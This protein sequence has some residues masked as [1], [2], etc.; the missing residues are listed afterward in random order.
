MNRSLV[1]RTVLSLLFF[2]AA[3]V[4]ASA[5][6]LVDVV[7][8][9][10]PVVYY[11]ADVPDTLAQ[12]E[13][14]PMAELWADPQVMAFFAPL[15]E[16]LEGGKW[17]E[18][19]RKETG[20]GLD[21]IMAMFTG[22]MVA[23]LESFEFD[24]DTPDD[25]PDISMAV[26]ADVGD[27][28]SKLE[29]LILRQEERADDENEADGDEVERTREVRDFRGIDLHIESVV[30]DNEVTDEYG[31]AVVEGV[32]AF[33]F[34]IATLE[35]AIAG[36]LDG[37]VED[38]LRSGVNFA[39]ITNH[40]RSSDAWF[41]FDIEPWVPTA[42]SAL[43]MG[44]ASAQ[45]AGSPFPVDP[46][47][48]MD[49]LGIESMQALFGAV[50]FDDRTTVMD[51]GLTYTEDRGLIK[52]AAYGPQVAPR[53]IFI[54]IDSDGFSSAT[55]DFADSWSALVD[56]INGVN[57]SLMGM[58]TMQLESMV[59]NAGVEL[60]LK[61]DLLENL[62]GEMVSIQ[63]LEGI[64]GDSLAELELQQDQVVA[65]GIEQGVA[66]DNLVETI[67]GMIGQGSQFFSQREFEGHT[68]FTLDLP[69]EEG[70]PEGSE[71]A[72]VITDSHLLMSFGSLATLEKVLLKLGTKSES[73]WKLPEVRKALGH[74]RGGAVAVQYQDLT[75]VGDLVFHGIAIAE[76]TGS[77]EDPDFRLCNPAAKPDPGVVAKYFASGVSGVWK[78]DR[79]IVMR[80]VVL[81]AERD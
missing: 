72:Y 76:K 58:A 71:I 31:W 21:E 65:L 73:V 8:D 23:Y 37:G 66:L 28:G 56:I 53:P 29:E 43:E 61:R 5:G 6:N 62:T 25:A 52:L 12:W 17:D 41:F 51:F 32:I 22:E 9:G 74:L 50:N 70:E 64:I 48:L 36:I 68:I 26:V 1:F 7:P 75:A 69:Q 77:D 14:S 15:R 38:P 30:E 57:P 44:L 54:P 35:S 40:T 4:P 81:P 2:V 33:G 39:T 63:N 34:P 45:E 13:G 59:Q 3:A 60:D 80:A 78:D 47:V 10:A 11:V 20:Y 67:K 79:S 18:M 19:V 49:A 24:L 27:N 16:D 55:F 42:R 46:A